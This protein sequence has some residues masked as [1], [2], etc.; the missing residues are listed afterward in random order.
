MSQEL[1][2]NVEPVVEPEPTPTPEPKP[3]PTPEPKDKGT[4]ATGGDPEPKPE[5]E[6]KPYWPE[7]WREKAAEHAAA[8]DDKAYK[9]EL[10]RLQRVTD[11][12]GLYGMYRDAESKLTQGGLVKV[13]GKDATEEDIAAYHKAQGVPDEPAGYFEHIKLDNGAVIGE[14]DKPVADSFAQAVHKEGAT[15]GVM[16]AAMNWYFTQQEEQAADLDIQDDDFKQESSRDLKDEF[17]PSL[18]RFLTGASALFASAPGGADAKN[19]ESLYARL[20]AGRMA[21]G[22][23]IGDDPHMNRF[24]IGL[25]REVRPEQTVTETGDQGG[26]SLAEELKDIQKLRRTDRR[27][28]DNDAAI[29]ARELEII[30]ALDKQKARA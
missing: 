4:I 20:M 8:G 18:G 9:R 16:N 17:G 29:Q 10:K 30:E 13:P 27:S 25:A 14:A 2:Q 26:R 23:I 11:P 24:L 21:D 3:E 28:Y 7:D 5:P 22:R 15:P 12:A 19:E 6:A 1:E